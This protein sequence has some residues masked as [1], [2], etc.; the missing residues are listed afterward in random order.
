MKK[1]VLTTP[2]DKLLNLA[3]G[4]YTARNRC[5][6]RC[7]RLHGY[8]RQLRRYL[9]WRLCAGILA[10]QQRVFQAPP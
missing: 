6:R 10:L 7:R 8:L 2:K 9:P 3:V 5:K 1:N 4:R